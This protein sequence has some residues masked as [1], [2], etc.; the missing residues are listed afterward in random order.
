VLMV[1]TQVHFRHSRAKKTKGL[2]L[3][4]SWDN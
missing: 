3:F 4:I 1:D 2:S